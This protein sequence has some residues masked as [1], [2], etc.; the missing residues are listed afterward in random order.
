MASGAA[1]TAVCPSLY[2]LIDHFLLKY[3]KNIK[4]TGELEDHGLQNCST[5][6]VGYS[7]T[8]GLWLAAQSYVVWEMLCTVTCASSSEIGEKRRR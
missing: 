7:A 4:E 6:H 2:F 8:M 1:F 5:S 3:P